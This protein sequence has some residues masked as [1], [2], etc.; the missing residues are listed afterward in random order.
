MVVATPLYGLN[1]VPLFNTIEHRKFQASYE[2][3][4]MIFVFLMIKTHTKKE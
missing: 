3:D 4:S 2:M 1:S